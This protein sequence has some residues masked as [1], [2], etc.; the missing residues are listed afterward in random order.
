MA[1]DLKQQLDRVAAK[2]DL[3]VERCHRLT[4]QRDEALVRV[5]ELERQLVSAEKEIRRLQV[6]NENLQLA[7]ALCPDRSDI[8]KAK[9]LLSELVR[10]IDRCILDLKE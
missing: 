4:Q 8:D 3:I 6:D 2:A 1:V 9:A 10:N 5:A 7:S